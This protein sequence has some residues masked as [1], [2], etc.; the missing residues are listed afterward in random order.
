MVVVGKVTQASDLLLE[1]GSTKPVLQVPHCPGVPHE[2]L[3]KVAQ[4]E[5]QEMVQRPVVVVD[6][7]PFRQAPQ[8][9]AEVQ[10]ARLREGQLTL[11]VTGGGV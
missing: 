7:K 10:V 11:Q 3:F 2:F 5:G 9:L 8:T 4:L 6:V 1:A